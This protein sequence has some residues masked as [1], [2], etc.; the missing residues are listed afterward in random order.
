MSVKLRM[1]RLGCANTVSFRLTA[2]DARS[3]RDGRVIE[4]LGHYDPTLKDESKQVSFNVERVQHWLKVGA[5]PSD[6]VRSL[7]K[8][9]GIKVS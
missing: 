6:T 8:K 9:Q 2:T 1:S 3:P 7:L 5:Q 4:Y